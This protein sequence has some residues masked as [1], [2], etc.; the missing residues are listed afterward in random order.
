MKRLFVILLAVM[1]H[2]PALAISIATGSSEGTY[3]KIAQDVKQ[4]AEKEGAELAGEV[5]VLD[6]GQTGVSVT[7]R[8]AAA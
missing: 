7:P 1:L 2:T 8:R 6:K 3:F 4:I 5:A